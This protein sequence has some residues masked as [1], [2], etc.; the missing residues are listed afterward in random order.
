MVERRR[1]YIVIGILGAGVVA[2]LTAPYKELYFF[3]LAFS[4]LMIAEYCL[5]KVDLPSWLRIKRPEV[6]SRVFRYAEIAKAGRRG[7]STSWVLD[8][9]LAVFSATELRN[10]PRE[11]LANLEAKMRAAE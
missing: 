9:K 7:A 4:A 1:A 6:R 11:E 10:L 3:V 8:N 2:L 5:R